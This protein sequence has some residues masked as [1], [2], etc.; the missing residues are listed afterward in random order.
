MPFAFKLSIPREVDCVDQAGAMREIVK[1]SVMPMAKRKRCHETTRVIAVTSGKGG[2]GKTN[3]T[4]NFAYLLSKRGK[5][6]LLLDADTGLA[7]VDV[8]LGITPN[9]NL[10]HL[11]H[12]EKNL[13]EVIVEGP[14]G[15]K[16]LPSA[17]GIQDMA[18][19][20]KGHKLTLLEELE[21]LD[22]DVDFMLIDTAAG[23]SGNV[24]YFN[25][26]A[27]EV[28]VVVSTEP[29]SLTDAYALIKMLYQGYRT[30]RFMLLVNMVGDATEAKGVYQRLNNATNHFLGFPIEYLGY[31]PLDPNV[32]KAVKKQKLLAQSFPDSK[33]T[34]SMTEIIEK[35]YRR[36]PEAYENGTIKFFDR[37]VM[38]NRG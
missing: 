20:S 1:E 28:I 17:S 38:G 19:L 2:V 24:M 11:L 35:L 14:G 13:A 26:A 23:I 31:I 4:A 34:V 18:E 16:I 21:G 30:R 9:Y 6:T 22:E 33:A 8:I 37:S 12:G 27:K 10:S 5:K 29:T 15:I 25:M 7:N 32:P 36:Q 3:I